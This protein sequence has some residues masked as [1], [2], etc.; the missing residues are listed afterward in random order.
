MESRRVKLDLG[1]LILLIGDLT[2]M[3]TNPSFAS[4]PLDFFT[5]F[6]IWSIFMFNTNVISRKCTN[7]RVDNL[8]RYY[9]FLII[10]KGQFNQ[11]HI[12]LN[13]AL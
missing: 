4:R 1:M 3:L 13:F 2:F 8:W 11:P 5:S 10:S 7:R 6:F 12:G 9:I